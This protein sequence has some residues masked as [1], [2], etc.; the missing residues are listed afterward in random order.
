VNDIYEAFADAMAIARKNEAKAT[1]AIGIFVK[2]SAEEPWMRTTNW[3]ARKAS[4]DEIKKTAANDWSALVRA[5]RLILGKER[6]D[7][8]VEDAKQRAERT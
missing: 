2:N 7:G 1:R 3:Y 8:L 4:L 5:A 6:M